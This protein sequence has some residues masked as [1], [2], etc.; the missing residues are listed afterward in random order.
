MCDNGYLPMHESTYTLLYVGVDIYF[1]GQRR[2][3]E[4]GLIHNFIVEQNVINGG[5]LSQNI[6]LHNIQKKLKKKKKQR[7]E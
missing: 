1:D 4:N 3:I 2:E 6:H 5:K 7:T